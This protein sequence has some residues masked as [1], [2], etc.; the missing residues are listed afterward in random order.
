MPYGVDIFD[1]PSIAWPCPTYDTSVFPHPFYFSCSSS[2]L[3]YPR[4]RSVVGPHGG[5]ADYYVSAHVKTRE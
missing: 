3:Q 5:M 1:I 2:Y 4:R